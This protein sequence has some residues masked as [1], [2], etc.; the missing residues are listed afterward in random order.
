MQHFPTFN[1]FVLSFSRCSVIPSGFMAGALRP[2]QPSIIPQPPRQEYAGDIDS[3]GAGI[4]HRNC[5][6][7]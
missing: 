5:L 7:A 2:A 1:G 4:F 3:A 6:R